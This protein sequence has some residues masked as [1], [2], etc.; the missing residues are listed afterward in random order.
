MIF[1]GD[2]SNEGEN[3][4]KLLKLLSLFDKNIPNLKRLYL[5][6][7]YF[8]KLPNYRSLVLSHL[9]NLACLDGL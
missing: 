6:G 2:N 5:A 4:E 1:K 9:K 3:S 8:N 7:N